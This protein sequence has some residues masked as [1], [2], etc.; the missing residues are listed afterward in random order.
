MI[1]WFQS[2]H[3]HL[4]LQN[5]AVNS[6]YKSTETECAS[7]GVGDGGPKFRKKYFPGNYHVKFG[8][9]HFSG[10]YQVKILEF[11]LLIF[12]AN[13]IKSDI[14]IF[15]LDKYHKKFGHFVNFSYTYF[16]A[17][18]SCP[19]SWL[20]SYAYVCKGVSIGDSQLSLTCSTWY[21]TGT[22]RDH[23]LSNGR[24]C[25]AVHT[26]S[27][28]NIIIMHISHRFLRAIIKH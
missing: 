11:W 24:G 10:K 15:F 1:G 12:Q 5:N 23:V 21:T 28:V 14:L 7:I 18:M 16:L 13:I 2:L 8:R 4:L 6:E 20:S 27:G 17:K 3:R 26:V 19:Q 9:W 22:I 25:C